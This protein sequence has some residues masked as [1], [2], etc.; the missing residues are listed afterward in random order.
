MEC[1]LEPF[2]GENTF[3]SQFSCATYQRCGEQGLSAVHHSTF[4]PFPI[5][6]IYEVH[7]C[8]FQVCVPFILLISSRI[9]TQK[10]LEWIQLYSEVP[11]DLLCL[12]V[13]QWLQRGEKWRGEVFNMYA[14]VFRSWWDLQ[15]LRV[16]IWTTRQGVGC[17]RKHFLEGTFR[18]HFTSS[19]PSLP[20]LML[21]V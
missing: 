17:I 9:K 10:S 6:L 7:C 4:F 5:Y 12:L 8:H 21:P 2:V 20:Y 13:T 1:L 16:F 18:L 19:Q 11:H 3:F 14:N 15:S